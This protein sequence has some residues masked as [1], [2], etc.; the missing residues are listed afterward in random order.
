MLN[1]SLREMG[2]SSVLAQAIRGRDVLR[3]LLRATEVEPPKPKQVFLSFHSVDVATSS[4]LRESVIAYRSAIRA[5]HSNFYP[6]VCD[7]NEAVEE[8]LDDTLR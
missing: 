5:R 3:K 4:F 8:E 7:A 2:G 6:I 1:L